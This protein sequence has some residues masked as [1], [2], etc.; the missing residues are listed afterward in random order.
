MARSPESSET[1]RQ[2][3]HILAGAPALLLRW[4]TWEQAALLAGLGVAFNL[5]VLPR[6][7]SRVFRGGDFARPLTSGIVLYPVA[8]LALILCFKTRLDIVAI[9]WVILAAGDG[10]ATIVGRN[11]RTPALP[12][13]REKSFGGLLAFVVFGS[14]AGMVAG[15]WMRGV[16]VG[17]PWSFF[18]LVAPTIAAGAAGLVETVPIRLNDNL[19]VPATA[20]LVVWS[21]TFVE[22]AAVRAALGPALSA[23]GPALALN[24]A[25]AALG[26]VAKT[27]TVPGAI[28]GAGIGVAVFVGAGVE[29]WLLLFA[30]FLCAAAVTRLGFRR[31]LAAGI[32]EARGGRRGAGNAIANTGLAAWA[33]AIS[34]GMNDPSLA[35]LAMVA[36]L[37]TSASDTVASEAGK[38]WG[39]TTWLLTGFRRVEPGTTGAVSL[40]GT[41]AGVAAAAALAA[42]AA[43]LGLIPAAWVAVVVAAA[44]VASIAEGLLGATLEPSGTLNNDALNFINTAIG[45]GLALAYVAF[46]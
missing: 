8:I 40:E 26:Y 4:I 10:F 37:V 29:G 12:W 14:I 18:L 39:R 23:I 38:A 41:L 9:V 20:A 28:I 21:F 30:S 16:F 3:L 17:A 42:L 2:I 19:S 24:V 5:V 44:T 1:R 33:A 36:A 46:K 34:L 32:A 22:Q 7:A 43:G 25:V 35:R 6:M 27:V 45:A 31:K 13:N 15:L 11:L